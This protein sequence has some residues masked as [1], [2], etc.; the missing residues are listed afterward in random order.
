MPSLANPARWRVVGETDSADYVLQLSLTGDARTSGNADASGAKRFEKLQGADA[1]RIEQLA[2]ED[3]RAR[4]F[5]GF[6]R[7]PLARI[8]ETN[9]ETSR[10]NPEASPA[11]SPRAQLFDLRFTEPG[12]DAR[13]GTFAV[14]L[15]LTSRIPER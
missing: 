1:Q 13:R 5:L 3:E 14:E 6:A 10:Q 9:A 11:Q 2:R 8:V 4:V 15:P 7:F 12:D